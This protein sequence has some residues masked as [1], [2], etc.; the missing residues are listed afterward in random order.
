[1]LGLTIHEMGD[2]LKFM[3][4]MAQFQPDEQ[5]HV[6]DPELTY[7]CGLPF[8]DILDGVNRL[9]AD[10][11]LSKSLVP[12]GIWVPVKLESQPKDVRIHLSPYEDEFAA[13]ED[14]EWFEVLSKPC[15]GVTILRPK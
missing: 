7:E 13:N 15:K 3:T 8:D 12:L 10:L 4:M 1:M 2:R 9:G 11:R 14:S 6:T 5:A